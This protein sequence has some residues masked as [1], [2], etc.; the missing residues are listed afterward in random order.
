MERERERGFCQRL[1]KWDR[2]QPK[3]L[4][5]NNKILNFLGLWFW[6]LSSWQ[7]Y[8]IRKL[9]RAVVRAQLAD[10]LLATLDDLT[11]NRKLHQAFT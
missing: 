8:P 4:S 6:C 1:K 3:K 11:S 5:A 9:S 10:R 7:S 2:A